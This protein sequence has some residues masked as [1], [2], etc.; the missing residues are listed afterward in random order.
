MLEGLKRTLQKQRSRRKF[1]TAVV[2]AAGSS[3]RMGGENKLL[4][5]LQG[6]P[7]IVRTLQA[8]QDAEYIDAIV[9]AAREEDLV[10]MAELF[11]T[12]G[13]AKPVTVVRGGETRLDS[14]LLAMAQ[15]PAETTLFA[16]QD[17]ARPLVTKRVIDEAVQKAM[18]CGA[19]A[20]AIPV[21]D[22]IKVA[23]ERVIRSTPERSTLFAVQT[24]QVFDAD[25][26]KAALQSARESG[27]EVTDDC[28]AVERLGKE[29]YL[30]DGSDQNL[31]ITT[32]SDVAAAEGILN[33]RM[34]HP[35]EE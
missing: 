15:A 35:W 14:V 22:T 10:S 7:V 4:L 12:Y 13:I 16:V 27:A 20:P 19:A 28:S 11:R 26:L 25:L 21:K 9:V 33:W 34:M 8:L 29:I 3:S 18:A 23:E 32:P 31:K 1:C 5:P 2:A 24:P 30:T 17:G 6:V